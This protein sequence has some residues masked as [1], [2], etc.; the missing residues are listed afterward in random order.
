MSFGAAVSTGEV[1]GAVD[2]MGGTVAVRAQHARQRS[3]SLLAADLPHGAAAL[4][5]DA[6]DLAVERGEAL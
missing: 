5:A 1:A 6:G 4:A 2:L 3:L